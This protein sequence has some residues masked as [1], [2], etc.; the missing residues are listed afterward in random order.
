MLILQEIAPDAS[1]PFLVDRNTGQQVGESEAI[2]EYLFKN[3]AQP[4]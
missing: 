3:Y 4:A 1:V 2:V